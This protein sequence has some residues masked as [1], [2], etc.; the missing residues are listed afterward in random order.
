M[1][2]AANAVDALFLRL[3][4]QSLDH[5]FVLLDP[6][7][8]VLAWRGAAEAL[9][10]YTEAEVVGRPI[11]FLF[12]E[13]D[14][15]ADLP[16]FERRVAISAGRSEDD[17]WHVRKDGLRMWVSG[18]VTPLREGESLLGFAKVMR[19][20]TDLRSQ[21]DTL[22]NRLSAQSR[23]LAD[24]DAIFARVMHEMRNTLGPIDNAATVIERST[25][26]AV[27]RLAVSVI[28]RQGGVLQRLVDDLADVARIDAGKLNL[29]QRAVELGSVLSLAVEAV[30]PHA[31]RRRQ[32]LTALIPDGPLTI[33]ADPERLH[34]IIFNLLDN[35]V[36]YTP[37]GGTIW[38]KCTTE[39]Q[40]VVVR[41]EDTGI[42]IPPELLPVI[43][44]LFTQESPDDAE[45]GYGVGL[46]L[47][48]DLAAAH[49]GSV[50]VRSEGR[51]KGSEFTVRLPLPGRPAG[52]EMQGA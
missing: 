37:E 11:S 25:D 51:G 31:Q 47:V 2:S 27:A 52:P 48:K 6:D 43:F 22:R 7:G 19:D 24:R 18:V 46:A 30:R 50:E 1:T 8:V 36:K 49:H 28:Q 20:R 34:Q 3:V 35:A 17:R 45:G 15:A 13:E 5:A 9:F 42:G 29:R 12:T 39:D 21:I 32:S 26:P 41:V 10:G 44:D 40:D 33:L 16:A 14:R 23:R 38:L 4:S